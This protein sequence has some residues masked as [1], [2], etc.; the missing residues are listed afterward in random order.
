M[1][2]TRVSLERAIQTGIDSALKEV[3]TVLPAI[4]TKVVSPQIIEC[5]P[6]IKIKINNIV[7]NLPLLLEV[8]LRFFRTANFAI[9][10]PIQV[11]DYVAVF[12]CQRSLDTWLN[13]GDIQDPQD[14]RRHSISDGFAIPCMYPNNDLVENVSSTDL[15]IRNIDNTAY[16]SLSPEG[17]ITLNAPAQ[18]VQLNG[19]LSIT[20]VITGS[21]VF[22]GSDSD[23]HKHTQGND[24]D[25]D[26]EVP[27]DPPF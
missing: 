7:S 19:D 23:E 3:F 21:N 20:G 25:N 1:S 22:G 14:I 16:I 9:T 2:D 18:G 27:T 26:I 17:L 8:P 10:I 5:Q 6:T 12:F 13:E 4:V 11:N 15:Q 24:S